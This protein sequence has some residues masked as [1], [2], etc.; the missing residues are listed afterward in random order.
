MASTAHGGQRPHNDLQ[1]PRPQRGP[2]RLRNERS[3]R[4]CFSFC[5]DRHV[6]FSC[7]QTFVYLIGG[8]CALLSFHNMTAVP[9]FVLTT[10][11]T[12]VDPET[13]SP[14]WGMESAPNWHALLGYRGAKL[15][16]D[17]ALFLGPHT[18]LLSIV[19]IA[20][21]SWWV[22]YVPAHAML[23]S[24]VQKA[25]SQPAEPEK[26]FS[27]ADTVFVGQDGKVRRTESTKDV[28]DVEWFLYD[29]V[30]GC[31]DL[32]FNFADG[33]RDCQ[34]DVDRPLY[35]KT[36]GNLIGITIHEN[37]R[38]G[39]RMETKSQHICFDNPL[40]RRINRHE[41]TPAETTSTAATILP[42]QSAVLGSFLLFA[43][44]VPIVLGGRPGLPNL[45]PI[46]VWVGLCLTI[47]VFIVIAMSGFVEA[48]DSKEAAPE[49]CT[50]R[51]FHGW[52]GAIGFL[53]LQAV[54][55]SEAI[56]DFFG[57][58]SGVISWI[59]FTPI[60]TDLEGDCR[61]GWCDRMDPGHGWMPQGGEA[62]NRPHPLSGR[63][64][65]SG[66]AWG[67]IVSPAICVLLLLWYC[68][69]AHYLLCPKRLGREDQL[70]MAGIYSELEQE[71]VSYSASSDIEERPTPRA[72]S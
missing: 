41:A 22:R 43:H 2:W 67:A 31:L 39:T 54:V 23:K 21:A 9:W 15:W 36:S 59:G 3:D 6:E 40:K 56:P 51:E 46:Q 30:D 33:A 12:N 61:Y 14:R 34:A 45:G 55:L 42:Q 72:F 29:L 18:A 71:V 66:S 52:L 7:K 53:G 50:A 63:G 48:T 5:G 57:V 10:P 26:L 19:L 1:S 68:R 8:I 69:V 64:P 28:Y 11:A 16:P 58:V 49:R 44:A 27:R 20:Y 32:P 35:D 4:H 65:Y 62:G 25:S 38:V 70:K 60:A 13:G 17:P 47:V 24:V 37:N